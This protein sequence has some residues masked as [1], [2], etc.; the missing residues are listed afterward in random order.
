MWG[1]CMMQNVLYKTKYPINI[2][3]KML[4]YPQ[5]LQNDWIEANTFNKHVPWAAG[6]AKLVTGNTHVRASVRFG[7]VGY[8]KASTLQCSNSAMQ[9]Y[10]HMIILLQSASVT[11]NQQSTKA[12][13]FFDRIK[14]RRQVLQLFKTWDFWR[15]FKCV[16]QDDLDVLTETVSGKKRAIS[17][18]FWR[19]FS[20][21][22][23]L[24][25]LCLVRSQIP[26]FNKL[27]STCFYEE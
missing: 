20:L 1:G 24:R 7:D 27:L 22:T 11:S 8:P 12:I 23:L 2:W 6:L 16:M 14:V 25:I 19:F 13:Y 18:Q 10:T 5:R 3:Q 26:T 4:Y 9:T 17:G 15:D 21:C